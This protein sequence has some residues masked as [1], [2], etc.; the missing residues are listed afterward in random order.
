MTDRNF[1]HCNPNCL[2]NSDHPYRILIIEG[3]GSGKERQLNLIII[4]HILTKYTYTQKIY[5]K[6]DQFLINKREKVGL[7]DYNN[8][9]DFI[10]CSNDM[11]GVYRNIVQCNPVKKCKTLIVF[12]DTFADTISNKKLNAIIS[13]WFIGRKKLFILFL[14]RNYILRHQKMLD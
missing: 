1:D 5:I 13:E 9:K 11:Q 3:F 10:E 14:L 12:D 2:Q 7:K 4:I 6:K 8:L